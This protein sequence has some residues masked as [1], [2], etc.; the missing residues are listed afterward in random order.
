MYQ[1]FIIYDTGEIIQLYESISLRKEFQIT[2]QY[3]PYL[4]VNVQ[5][6]DIEI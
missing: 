5:V 3:F 1:E 2:G 6:I 4:S